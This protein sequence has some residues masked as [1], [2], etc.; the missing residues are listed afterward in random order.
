MLSF[1]NRLRELRKEKKWTQNELGS[2]LG[3][4]E[5][6]VT[7][8]ERGTRFPRPDTI[9]KI[10]KIFNVTTDYLL[11]VTDERTAKEVNLSKNERLDRIAQ[12]NPLLNNDKLE[13]VKNISEEQAEFLMQILKKRLKDKNEN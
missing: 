6:L 1:G 9:V 12:S 10:S 7:H 2:N 8:Y 11:G 5:N 13:I 4:G 3:L